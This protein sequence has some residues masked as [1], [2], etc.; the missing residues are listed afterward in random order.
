MKP[1]SSA[2]TKVVSCVLCVV[3]VCGVLAP[4]RYQPK[5]IST[6]QAPQRRPRCRPP[7]SQNTK[8]HK[9]NRTRARSLSLARVPAT[10]AGCYRE[11]RQAAEAEVSGQARR[12]G[13]A[14][15]LCCVCVCARARVW[16]RDVDVWCCVI[17]WAHAQPFINII[18]T[19]NPIPLIAARHRSA[20]AARPVPAH[21]HTQTRTS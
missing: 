7:P 18:I 8:K 17:D 20:I 13:A 1:S 21:T 16:M 11:Q 2:S 9:T 15:W 12:G 6:S 3:F 10:R 19:N 4:L 14:L 5:G